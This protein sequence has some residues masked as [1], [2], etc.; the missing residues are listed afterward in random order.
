[1][2]QYKVSLFSDCEF[3]GEGSRI[4]DG[5]SLSCSA[6]DEIWDRKFSSK[7]EATSFFR[8]WKA[9]GFQVKFQKIS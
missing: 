4:C 3:W 9:K 1:M 8:K 5:C 6:K 7:K 2:A